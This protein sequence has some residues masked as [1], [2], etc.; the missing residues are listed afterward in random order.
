MSAF[1]RPPTLPLQTL[2]EGEGSSKT[3][4]RGRGGECH[5]FLARNL[6]VLLG[7][8]CFLAGKSHDCSSF[9]KR[10]F[11]KNLACLAKRFSSIEVK[12]RTWEKNIK[13]LKLERKS[14]K[15]YSV[16]FSVKGKKFKLLNLSLTTSS[17]L[18]VLLPTRSA[19][20][21][22]SPHLAAVLRTKLAELVPSG[23]FCPQPWFLQRS[24]HIF[25]R[26]TPLFIVT[27]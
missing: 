20:H 21:L 4:W 18:S 22:S 6:A 15:N 27:Q 13:Y 2:R 16:V 8:R 19:Q 23:F 10:G 3:T 5:L 9:W 1:F 26:K 25:P 7:N 11:L 17:L 14:S 12:F 24:E